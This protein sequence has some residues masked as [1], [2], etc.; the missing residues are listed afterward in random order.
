LLSS[1]CRVCRVRFGCLCVSC[2]VFVSRL[3]G[4]PSPSP[5][6]LVYLA[7]GARQDG[8]CHRAPL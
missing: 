1:S 2:F 7:G 6:P 4:S 5:C 3:R 8:R